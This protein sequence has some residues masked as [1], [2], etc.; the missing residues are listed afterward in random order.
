[1]GYLFERGRNLT[2]AVRRQQVL[3]SNPVETRF[4]S[5]GTSK[6]VNVLYSCCS[7]EM[8]VPM[9]TNIGSSYSGK[10]SHF[11]PN[12]RPLRHRSEE[13]NHLFSKTRLIFSFG[14]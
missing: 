9:L 1:M 13:F 4:D 3:C 12:L 6:G 7:T 10:A 5:P 11:W 2:N 8:D 14:D